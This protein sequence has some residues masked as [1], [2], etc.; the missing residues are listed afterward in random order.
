MSTP[1]TNE[2][3]GVDFDRDL[4]RLNQIRAA[5]K[6]ARPTHENPAWMNTHADCA[7][8]LGFIDSLWGAYTTEVS[9]LDR[10]R[11]GAIAHEEWLT[12][13]IDWL[14]R[15]MDGGG[16]WNHLSTRRQESLYILEKLRAHIP[17][18][19]EVKA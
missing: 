7:F 3:Q 18:L 2:Q 1:L 13:R 5:H 14:K 4:E 12:G 10:S 9:K 8:L 11:S 6:S 16:D 15:E 17:A 19:Q